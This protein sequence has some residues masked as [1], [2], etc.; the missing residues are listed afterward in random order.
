MTRN[1]Y[2]TVCVVHVFELLETAMVHKNPT[3]VNI[4]GNGENVCR[5]AGYSFWMKGLDG[6]YLE[7]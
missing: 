2:S 4:N 6:F 7:N 1:V 3:C 5:N